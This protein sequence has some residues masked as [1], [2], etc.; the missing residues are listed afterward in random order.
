MRGQVFLKPFDEYAWVGRTKTVQYTLCFFKWLII[1]YLPLWGMLVD[2]KGP[3]FVA[4][5]GGILFGS[6]H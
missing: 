6:A 4:T 1:D 3:R 5:I 2:K